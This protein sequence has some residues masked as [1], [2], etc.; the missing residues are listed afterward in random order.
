[1]IIRHVS[2]CV[3]HVIVLSVLC[4]MQSSNVNFVIYAQVH[5]EFNE[6]QEEIR[7]EGPPEDAE[8]A[9][10][11][12]QDQLNELVKLYLFICC[13]SCLKSDL[14]KYDLSG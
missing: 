4:L 13:F 5:I 3:L 11:I 14:G 10:K 6:E 9:E 8:Q 7:L 12:I 1:M 2:K